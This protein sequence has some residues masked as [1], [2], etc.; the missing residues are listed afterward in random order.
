MAGII[1]FRTLMP[2]E[3]HAFYSQRCGMKLWLDQGGCR[4]YRSDNLLLGFCPREE[5]DLNGIITFFVAER[6]QVDKI[7]QMM[8]DVADARPVT[9]PTTS[10][11][12]SFPVTRKAE[13]WN[14]RALSIPS[15]ISLRDNSGE[16]TFIQS[17]GSTERSDSC[18]ADLLRS[19]ALPIF[20]V[21]PDSDS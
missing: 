4:I 10:F 17:P 14:F 21:N 20:R 13:R 7:Y 15:T 5:A 18:L 2:E 9:I 12:S 16:D 8:K 1:F 19:L 6:E 3:L 11:T